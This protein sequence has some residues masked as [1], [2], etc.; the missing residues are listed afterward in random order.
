MK[1]AF[2]TLA[3]CAAIHAGSASAQEALPE[4]CR[5][6]V[7]NI[8]LAPGSETAA[9]QLQC[10]I[11]RAAILA[12]RSEMIHNA[13]NDPVLRIVD[14][15]APSGA[16]Y[17]YD[18]LDAGGTM[19]LD[20]RTVP[21]SMDDERPIP[22]CRLEIRLPDD[23]AA[24]VVLALATS[25]DIPAYGARERMV[26]NADGSRSFELLLDAHDVITS[27]ETPGGLRNFSR[28][29]DATDEIARLNASIIGV[30]NFSDAW[31]CNLNTN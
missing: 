8:A 23:V 24:R 15:K 4:S 17:V 30:A 6:N 7:G 1:H 27:I 2:R 3:L 19:M 21:S 10:D 18:I 29:A 11:D 14:T 31:V 26:T 20:A 13:D 22:L 28:H 5:P 12:N 9:A 25:D 16:A